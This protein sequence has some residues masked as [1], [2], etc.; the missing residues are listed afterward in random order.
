MCSATNSEHTG[1]LA[2]PASSSRRRRFNRRRWACALAALTQLHAAR[3]GSA[4]TSYIEERTPLSRTMAT[5]DTPK[6]QLFFVTPRVT[7]PFVVWALSPF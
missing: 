4:T 6:R 7:P 3:S 1:E 2:A 5:K